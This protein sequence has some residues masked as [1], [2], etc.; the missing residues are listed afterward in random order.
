MADTFKH[1]AQGQLLSSGDSPS[2]AQ[3]L[4]YEAPAGTTAIVGHIRLANLHGSTARTA[5]LWQNGVADT[6]IVLPALSIESGGWAEFT[7]SIILD[8]GDILYGVAN[9]GTSVTYNIYGLEVT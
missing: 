9:A 8:A 7:G 3:Q 4:L 1:L 2:T 6:N 5:K